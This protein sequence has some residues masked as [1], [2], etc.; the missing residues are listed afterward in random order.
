MNNLYTNVQF[1]FASVPSRVSRFFRSIKVEER[2]LPKKSALIIDILIL[3][4]KLHRTRV[5]A[6]PALPL[7]LSHTVSGK[8][9]TSK[10]DSLRRP[11]NQNWGELFRFRVHVGNGDARSKVIRDA[12]LYKIFS[13][14]SLIPRII[15]RQE[16]SWNLIGWE[17]WSTR[18]RGAFFRFFIL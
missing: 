15:I 8:K 17:N 13:K 12:G 3:G 14:T 16:K 11:A 10:S 9:R 7:L 5:Y 6:K 1:S 2:F 18:F 4:A